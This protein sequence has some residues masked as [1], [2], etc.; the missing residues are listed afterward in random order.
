MPPDAILFDFDGLVLDTETSE[1]LTVA[2]SFADHGLDLSRDDWV[3]IIGTADHPHWM[4]MLEEALGRPLDDREAILET[5]RARHHA[6]ISE[7]PLRPGVI[8]LA[9]AA[10]E[11]GVGVAIASSSPLDWVTG[12]LQRFDVDHL[13][14]VKATRDDVGKERTKPH[15]DLFL[16]AAERLGVD[17]TRCVVLEDS[18]PG[19]IAA[20]AAGCA[21]VGVPAG[22]TAELAFTHADLVV[23]SVAEL[24]LDRLK[25]LFG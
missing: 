13:F 22:M 16:L 6:R 24:D 8:E 12:H 21:T 23:R 18:E 11:A 25:G 15:P 17:P 9:T 19:V 1:F 5:R 20:N 2:E 10:T 4:D 7:E 3:A 14:P